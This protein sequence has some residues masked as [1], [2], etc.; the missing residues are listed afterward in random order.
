M[1]RHGQEFGFGSSSRH[2]RAD[3]DRFFAELVGPRVR[4]SESEE[5]VG[6]WDA[7][8][9]WEDAAA[10]KVTKGRDA[11]ELLVELADG[12]KYRVRR[13]VR[14][15]VLTRP[16][17]PRI[18]FC[19]DDKRVFFRLSWCE[20]TQGRIDMGAN[21][22]GA[23]KDLMDKVMS[24]IKARK[25]AD[26][27]RQTIEGAEVQAFL[28]IDIAEVGSWKVTGEVRLEINREGIASTTGSL[29]ADAGWATFG[30]K[31]TDDPGEKKVLATIDIPLSKRPV[32]GKTCPE[33]ELALWWEIECFREVQSSLAIPP[34]KGFRTT[35][36]P[37][38]R[39][40]FDHAKDTLRRDASA[41]STGDEMDD[42]VSS[43]PEGGTA[44]LNKLALVELDHLVGQGYFLEKVRGYTSPEGRRGPP[45]AGS[46]SKW[47][48][49]DELSRERAVKVVTSIGL[50]YPVLSMRH[51]PMRFPRG[52]KLP[53]GVPESEMPMLKD[54]HGR[55]IEG[56]DLDRLLIDGDKKLGVRPFLDQYPH[57]R[58]WMTK[59]DR[60]FI[61]NDRKR[62]RDRAER[63]FENLRR[64]EIHVIRHEP[65]K[66]GSIADT[67]LRREP[68]CPDAVKEAVA[69]EWGTMIPFTKADP[70]LCG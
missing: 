28:E 41:P 11:N 64:V 37:P 25:S 57:E 21:P 13:K 45:K 3:A 65:Y 8:E 20:G 1:R 36:V 59:G 18:G 10:T 15:Q 6:F 49:N 51:P 27:I 23:F 33:R 2:Q 29:T 53:T 16:G 58:D 34:P 56:R 26:E 38:L 30:I 50:R 9:A 35:R 68:V 40:Y 70:P 46:S 14:A 22:Q 61:E 63:L 47:E 5:L 44:L 19:K 67:E 7:S 31:Y 17:R 54:R 66:G 39:L 4:E 48:G 42:I 12:T 62:T 24:Q 52:F 69:G 55:E 32:T 43:A 60:K